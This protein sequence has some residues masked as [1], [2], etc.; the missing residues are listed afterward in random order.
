MT[1]IRTLATE[2]YPSP[3]IIAYRRQLPE[4]N[5]LVLQKVT[6]VRL[7]IDCHLLILPDEWGF[8]QECAH[9]Q[10]HMNLRCSRGILGYWK[11][12]YFYFSVLDFMSEPIF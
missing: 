3:K 6:Y 2:D 8:L 9:A 7:I 12:L 11:L 1:K 5:R 4:N 10:T